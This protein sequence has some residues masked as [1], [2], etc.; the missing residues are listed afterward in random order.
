LVE[1]F[2]ENGVTAAELPDYQ[3]MRETSRG[4]Q[5]PYST[6]S[7]NA[8]KVLHRPNMSEDV[9]DRQIEVLTAFNE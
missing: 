7:M 4:Y 3:G 5:V 9:I 1:V 6:I 8:K 2:K